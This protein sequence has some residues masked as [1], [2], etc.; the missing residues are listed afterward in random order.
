MPPPFAARAWFLITYTANAALCPFLNLFFL[1][2]GVSKRRV[3]ALAAV[4]PL[5]AAAAGNAWSLAAD[6]RGAHRPIFLTCYVA[7][8]FAKYGL[9]AAA[10]AGFGALLVAVLAVEILS[11]PVNVLADAC[12]I[13]ASP[14]GAGDYGKTR[15]WGA[16]GWGLGAPLGGWAVGAYGLPAAFAGSAAGWAVGGLFAVALPMGAIA[17]AGG[18]ERAVPASPPPPLVSVAEAVSFDAHAIKEEAG[19]SSGVEAGAG[20]ALD[21][22]LLRPRTATAARRLAASLTTPDALVFL[23][24]AANFG[25]AMGCIDTW[26]FV[27]LSQ[28]LAA[29]PILLGATLTVTCAAEVPVLALAGRAVARWGPGRVWHV[30]HGARGKGAWQHV[31]RGGR[32]RACA[33]A[34]TPPP[35]P[36]Q[37]PSYCAWAGTAPCPGSR[38]PGGSWPRNRCTA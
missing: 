4:R 18:G 26:L 22:P 34:P 10:K 36:P 32:A 29:P 28:D 17:G 30:V 21:A 6:A 37:S 16:I 25:A 7:A 8:G 13:A 5:V 19:V 35:T 14:R 33:R 11:A 1:S 38:P 31:F 23:A 2:A 9:Q 27:V 3:G 24:T 15:L 12:A 20:A